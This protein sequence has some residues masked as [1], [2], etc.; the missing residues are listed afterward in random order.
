MDGD[1][2][3]VTSP[4]GFY[5]HRALFLQSIY[6]LK[7]PEEYYLATVSEFEKIHALGGDNPI[8]LWF[9]HDLFCQVNLWYVCSLL[10]SQSNSQKQ[11]FI[12]RPSVD[13]PYSFSTM[14]NVDYCMA[15]QNRML[16]SS[17]LLQLYS[18]LWNAW[19]HKDLALLD[20]YHCQSS[21]VYLT[22]AIES[23]IDIVSARHKPN[24]IQQQLI[25]LVNGLH[26]N[27]FTM[28]FEAFITKYP[29]YGFGDLQI[30]N[31][32]HKMMFNYV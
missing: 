29:M 24:M 15:Y 6:A 1:F 22:Q 2:P 26:T 25:Q 4:I 21:C 28:I 3:D 8:N 30:K 14:S 31:E 32:L 9:E 18:N 7:T 13:T 23:V 19:L 16:A 10:L 17:G 11:V 20:K 27:D 5:E 12:V